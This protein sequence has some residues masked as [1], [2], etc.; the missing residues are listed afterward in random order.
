MEPLTLHCLPDDY[1][2]QLAECAAP[3]WS[4]P[5]S[6]GFP[7]LTIEQGV[8][9]AGAVLTLWAVAAAVRWVNRSIRQ[10]D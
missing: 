3:F 4:F 8:A 10:S 7:P 6:S 9:L 5:N 2:A 1:D